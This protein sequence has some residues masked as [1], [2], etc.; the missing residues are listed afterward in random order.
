[1]ILT[2]SASYIED[3]ELWVL[4]IDGGEDYFPIKACPHP[5]VLLPK[6]L[7]FALSLSK[8]IGGIF[9]RVRHDVFSFYTLDPFALLMY[10]QRLLV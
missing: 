4:Q 1:M 10:N 6:T 7:Q 9:F 5:G 3:P 8:E 2:I